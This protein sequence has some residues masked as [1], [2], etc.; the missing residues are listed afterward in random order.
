MGNSASYPDIATG[1]QTYTPSSYAGQRQLWE[2]GFNTAVPEASRTPP[3]LSTGSFWGSSA[4]GVGKI[5]TMHHPQVGAQMGSL[6]VN[7]GGGR[8]NPYGGGGIIEPLPR[9]AYTPTNHIL[10][11]KTRATV[12]PVMGG[13][14]VNTNTVSSPAIVRWDAKQEPIDNRNAS[15]MY[16]SRGWGTTQGGKVY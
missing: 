11:Q 7:I 13:M 2:P 10:T 6:T 5:T 14:A 4:L 3:T 8:L 16:Q 15:M 9:L 1:A 12:E